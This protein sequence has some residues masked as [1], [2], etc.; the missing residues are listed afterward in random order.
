MQHFLA[1]KGEHP[2]LSRRGN[3][4]L[5]GPPRQKWIAPSIRISNAGWPGARIATT[6]ELESSHFA[7]LSRPAEIAKL[8]EQAAAGSAKE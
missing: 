1:M 5:A 4:S 7:Y 3:Q 8:I 2:S 6:V